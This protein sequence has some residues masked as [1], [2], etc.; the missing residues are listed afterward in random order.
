MLSRKVYKL[1]IYIFPIVYVNLVAI[2][3]TI[4]PVTNF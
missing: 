3:W 2:T 1:S 4:T